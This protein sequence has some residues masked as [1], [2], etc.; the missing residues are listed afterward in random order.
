MIINITL[1]KNIPKLKGH[2]KTTSD[3][4]GDMLNTDLD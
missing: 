2:V 3:L 4:N 1:L